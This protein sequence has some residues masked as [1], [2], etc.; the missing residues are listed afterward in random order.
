MTSVK[1]ILHLHQECFKGIEMKQLSN[2]ENEDEF[3][4]YGSLNLFVYRITY[5]KYYGFFNV[6]ASWENLQNEL[7][8]PIIWASIIFLYI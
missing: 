5:N 6:Y 3:L 2:Y 8:P 4:I 7:T 1:I